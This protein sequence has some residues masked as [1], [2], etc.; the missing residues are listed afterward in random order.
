ML[1][2]KLDWAVDPSAFLGDVQLNL[3]LLL[4]KVITTNSY[5]VADEYG[6]F[7]KTHSE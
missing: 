1:V 7:V 2:S 4:N 6:Y 3:K 5:Y